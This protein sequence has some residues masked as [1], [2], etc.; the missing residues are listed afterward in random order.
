MPRGP[1]GHILREKPTDS[2]ILEKQEA[3]IHPVLRLDIAFECRFTHE[4]PISPWLQ[5]YQSHNAIEQIQHNQ[6][7]FEHG[8]ILY[9]Y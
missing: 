2:R 8:E 4:T 1:H 6:L 7:I 9:R 3:S 5:R